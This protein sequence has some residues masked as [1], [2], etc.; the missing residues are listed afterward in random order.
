M[1]PE[2][3]G[4]KP[5]YSAKSDMYALGM[6][7][8]EMAAN[9]TMPFSDQS[10]NSEARELVKRGEREELP[11]NTPAV[12]RHWVERCWEHHP[13]KRLDAGEMTVDDETRAIQAL[14][15]QCHAQVKL[16]GLYAKGNWVAKD[17]SESFR[18]YMQAASQG[19][20]DAQFTVG[21]LFMSGCG[22]PV[23]R[24]AAAVWYR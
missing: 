9:S 19:H 10:D 4:R 2:V 5:Q 12:Y 13:A 22:T 1:A 16:A 24:S 6:V 11:E 17:E 7:M 8:W 14:R 20:V 21:E 3:F 23:S 18:W 15:Q